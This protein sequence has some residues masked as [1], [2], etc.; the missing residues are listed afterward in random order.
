A[1]L[2]RLRGD[3]ALEVL[4]VLLLAL[5]TVGSAWCAYQASQW[6]GEEA[7]E[8]RASTDDR[9]E[10][11]RLFSLGIQTIS[12]DAAVVAQYAEAYAAG[13]EQLMAFYRERLVRPDFLSVI[14]A[15]EQG[16]FEGG[17]LLDNPDYT[18]A[19][20]GSY[21]E[22][23]ARAE[24][25]TER[26]QV[27]GANADDYVVLTLVLAS[28]LFFAGVTSSFRMRAL[29]ILLLTLSGVA[30]AGVAARLADLPIT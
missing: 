9:V 4:S 3:R 2:T 16:T 10:A 8:A 12:Y 15:L 25:A 28:A 19:Q 23:V 17:N 27:A 26:S 21:N 5:A 7:L 13:N 18:Q 20:L 11:S 14:D 29:R 24:A 6:N 1:D 22:T 30:V